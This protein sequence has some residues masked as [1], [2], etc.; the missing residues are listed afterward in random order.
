M[1]TKLDNEKL[2]KKIQK[3]LLYHHSHHDIEGTSERYDPYV[4]SVK[5]ENYLKTL[6]L[7]K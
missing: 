2:F 5:L 4:N 7:K 1:A 3:W 6:L